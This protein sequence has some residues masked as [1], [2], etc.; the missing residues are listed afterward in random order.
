MRLL[1]VTLKD[2]LTRIRAAGK[3][4]P[5]GPMPGVAA[6]RKGCGA[7]ELRPTLWMRPFVLRVP[8]LK[9]A[10]GVGAAGA[11]TVAPV[12]PQP[13]KVR[14][15]AGLAPTAAPLS[16]AKRIPAARGVA[17]GHHSVGAWSTACT[18]P[19]DCGPKMVVFPVRGPAV[20]SGR[21]QVL[22]ARRRLSDT[23]PWAVLF[24]H[25]PCRGP[26][27]RKRR[28][29]QC[30]AWPKGQ[31]PRPGSADTTR[32][33]PPA[34]AAARPPSWRTSAAKRARGPGGSLRSPLRPGCSS[35]VPAAAVSRAHHHQRLRSPSPGP[36]PH[37]LDGLLRD[38]AFASRPGG[39][40]ATKHGCADA[41][42]P[43]YQVYS[44]AL[45]AAG[46]S[47]SAVFGGGGAEA[48]LWARLAA[49]AASP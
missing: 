35:R 12:R 38:L 9:G 23:T 30:P 29:P 14:V 6:P 49:A 33:A 31:A 5:T 8:A 37:L 26:W 47:S 27:S 32:G 40:P 28:V 15:G 10:V 19:M 43:E 34:G 22:H 16:L 39:S 24:R 1:A 13:V 48:A 44:P 18:L 4:W 21:I 42:Q 25:L 7:A 41:D 17:G 20:D 46:R 11:V 45:S 2:N 36:Q 3:I